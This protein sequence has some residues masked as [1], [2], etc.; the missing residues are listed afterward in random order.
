MFANIHAMNPYAS[1]DFNRISVKK[2]PKPQNPEGE[3][4]MDHPLFEGKKMDISKNEL[5]AFTK[6]MEHDEFKNIMNDYVKEISDPKNQSEYETYLRQLEE[7]GDLP[8]GT[9]L[10]KPTAAFCI[11]TTS[12]KL[13]SDINKTFFDQKTFIN[14][15]MHEDIQK[16]KREFM[17]NE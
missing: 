11:K 9:K 15:C 8:K 2:E 13:V 7:A 1:E 5:K 4:Q 16:P 14:V 12:K 10:I 3:E 17:T 6:A